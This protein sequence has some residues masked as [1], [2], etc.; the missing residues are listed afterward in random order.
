MNHI[1]LLIFHI[2][3]ANESNFK[4]V[5]SFFKATY[6][7]LRV[8]KT[9]VSDCNSFLRYFYILIIIILLIYEVLKIIE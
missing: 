5:H 8:T 2:K 3:E 7:N 6:L 9:I 1:I 4:L